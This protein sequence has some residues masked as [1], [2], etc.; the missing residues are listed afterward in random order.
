M[1]FGPAGGGRGDDRQRTKKIPPD[2]TPGENETMNEPMKKKI[3]R[4]KPVLRA[5][6]TAALAPCPA[7]P[8][9]PSARRMR[10]SLTLRLRDTTAANPR[11]LRYYD[12]SPTEFSPFSK[13]GYFTCQHCISISKP[14][15]VIARF[16]SASRSALSRIDTLRSAAR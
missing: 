9:R 8:A 7:G 15:H 10:W 3:P 1:R 16:H 11:S 2:K 5:D 4:S 14:S 13:R 12:D 6:L